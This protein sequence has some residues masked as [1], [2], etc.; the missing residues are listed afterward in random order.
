MIINTECTRTTPQCE[1]WQQEE[2][3]LRPACCTDKLI[4]MIFSISDLLAA[5]NVIY[6]LD[7]G[8]LLGAVRHQEL[9]PWDPEADIS[10][11]LTDE[12]MLTMLAEEILD[13]GYVVR[14]NP[15]I[16]DLLK[17]AYSEQNHNYVDLF[18]FRLQDGL[19]KT[20]CDYDSA[21]WDFPVDY[22]QQLETV[23]LHGRNMLAPSPLHAFLSEHRYGPSYQ[24]PLRFND[25]VIF[26]A[27]EEFTPNVV[28]LCQELECIESAVR[29][30]ESD[31]QVAQA[32]HTDIAASSQLTRRRWILARL[33]RLHQPEE[34][35]AFFVR[36]CYNMPLNRRTKV[37]QPLW[38]YLK[39][40][41]FFQHMVDRANL[42]YVEAEEITPAAYLILNRIIRQQS[43][44]HYLETAP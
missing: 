26:F 17:V 29:Q 23:T 34:R 31:K 35:F 33:R 43:R 41:G 14:R 11:Y 28:A 27:P 6:W 8:T 15:K 1:Q 37:L 39:W 38:R 25:L 16:P 36:F 40:R 20:E 42:R 4:E 5:H 7:F 19:L 30:R 9:I 21:R 13:A 22:I 2:N 24:I 32:H 18:A 44:M 12:S 10:F 3:G